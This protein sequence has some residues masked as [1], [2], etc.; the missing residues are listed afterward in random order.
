MVI[1][2]VNRPETLPKNY[3][4]SPAAYPE[5]IFRLQV[6]AA[7]RY[8]FDSELQELLDGAGVPPD[9]MESNVTGLTVAHVAYF[10]QGLMSVAGAEKALAY[11][12]DSFGKTMSGFT[13]S[14]ATLAP[15]LRGPASP[16]KAFLRIRDVM[17][18]LNRRIG[19]NVLTKWHGGAGCDLF[20][21]TGYHC[22]G[23]TAD[24]AI[25][26]TIT[27]FLEEAIMALANVKVKLNETECM[28]R[29]ALACRW[30]CD[31]I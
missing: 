2:T 14:T 24:G 13:R 12:R 10:M 22:Y 16:D 21:D 18:D 30:H 7:R 20:E 31:L 26:H 23:F 11:G 29:G 19:A 8:L 4:E 6:E 5:S 25:C 9:F 28:A 17:S 1:S 27:G 15:I 3:P